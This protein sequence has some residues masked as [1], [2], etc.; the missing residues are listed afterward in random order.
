MKNIC[1][2]LPHVPSVVSARCSLPVQKKAGWLEAYINSIA[3]MPYEFTVYCFGSTGFDDLRI[4]NIVFKDV[5]DSH[6]RGIVNRIIPFYLR[7]RRDHNSIMDTLK[8]IVREGPFDLI[9]VHGSETGLGLIGSLTE[10]PVLLSLQGLKAA[11]SPKFYGSL[12][13]RDRFRGSLSVHGL[14]TLVRG[15]GLPWGGYYSKQDSQLEKRVIQCCDAFLGKTPFDESIIRALR[16]DASYYRQGIYVRPTE[17]RNLWKPLD[18]NSSYRIL[19]VSAGEPYKGLDVLVSAVSTAAEHLNKPVELQIIGAIPASMRAILYNRFSGGSGNFTLS[20]PGSMPAE[21]I[22]E[23]IL[24]SDAFVI[25]SFIENECHA[26]LEAMRLGCP[27]ITTPVGGIK[28]YT[29]ESENVLHFDP[30]ND[31]ELAGQLIRILLDKSLQN[32][33]GRNAKHTVSALASPPLPDILNT[34]YEKAW[35]GSWLKS[36]NA[37]KLKWGI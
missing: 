10:N 1:W 26:L 24:S 32:S 23:A 16:N 18:D 9:H 11:I 14:I 17:A 21:F 34:V 27:C 13:L 37:R 25:S 3:D 22:D 12:R 36:I 35:D 31:I 4:G 19:C 5:P 20:L 15:Y 28:F 2:L 30:G 7:R 8:G 6:T 29:R 33:L